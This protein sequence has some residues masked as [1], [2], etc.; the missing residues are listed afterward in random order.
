MKHIHNLVLDDILFKMAISTANNEWQYIRDKIPF[1]NILKEFGID[2]LKE[3]SEH[4]YQTGA[5]IAGGALTH[6][7]FNAIH[8]ISIPLPASSD[9]DIW[10]SVPKMSYDTDPDHYTHMYSRDNRKYLVSE[11]VL[12]GIGGDC[13]TLTLAAFLTVNI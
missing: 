9:L 3:F 10:I 13:C 12:S 5:Y 4:M 8:K 7:I 2:D 1:E 6:A 11:R